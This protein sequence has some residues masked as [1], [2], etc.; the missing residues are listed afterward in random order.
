[1]KL[2]N[3]IKSQICEIFS[4]NKKEQSWKYFY[5]IKPTNFLILSEDK[6]Q[7]KLN[8]FFGLLTSIQKELQITLTRTP[9]TIDYK[10]KK[11]EMQ[12]LQ[13]LLDSTE[14]LDNILEK[15]NIDFSRDEE[16]YKLTVSSEGISDFTTIHND[17]KI[18]GK[19][20]TLENMPSSLPDAWIHRIFDSFHRLQIHVTPI[21]VDKAHKIIKNKKALYN[22]KTSSN[23][24]DD[25]RVNDIIQLSKEIELGL[26]KLYS[27]TINGFIFAKDYKTIRSLDKLVRNNLSA[28]NTTMIESY[29]QQE[30]IVNGG[31]VSWFGSLETTAI[32]YPFVSA[33]MLET[34]NGIVLGINKDTDSPVIYDSKYRKNHNIYTCGGMGS[35]KSFTGKIMLKRFRSLHPK[36]MCIVIDPQEEYLPHAKY[37][38]LDKIQIEP[39]NQY[40]LNPF[41]LFDNNAEVIDIIAAMTGANVTVAKQW[42][43]ICD[44]VSSIKELH[45]KSETDGKEYLIDLI[46]GPISKMFEGKIKFSDRMIISLKKIENQEIE[47]LL[48]LLVLTWAWKR[49]NE[50]PANQWKYLLLDE[51][52]RLTKL[53]ESSQKLGEI[54]RQGRKRSLIFNV[55]TQNYN[56]LDSIMSVDSKVVDLFDTKII[57]QLG[58]TAAKSVRKA[59]DLEDADEERIENFHKGE[60]LIFT[61]DNTIFIKFEA[62]EKERL[63]YFNTD[64]EKD[65]NASSNYD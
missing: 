34:P 23:Y 28:L 60:G 20:F 61:S 49:I 10:N 38:G 57:M 43:S 4:T 16:H 25:K 63:D 41:K 39:G 33:D 18:I 15:L 56:D 55:I 48:I 8:D 26:T 45:E 36:T 27:F 19:G 44:T 46:Q 65:E 40:G 29:G 24:K 58:N 59:L 6:Q 51:A 5:N 14:P 64:E 11:T 42:R 53:K 32:F 3:D 30:N 13:V 2:M 35:G 50:L 47:K 9:I 52:W 17:E 21:K 31:G 1:M 12:V 54:T 37:F 7:K 22:D 62:T